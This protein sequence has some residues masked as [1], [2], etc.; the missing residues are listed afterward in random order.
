MHP[1]CCALAI[2]VV[3]AAAMAGCNW[4]GRESASAGAGATKPQHRRSWSDDDVEKP[5]WIKDPT[6]GGKFIAAWGSAAHDPYVDTAEIRDRAVNSARKE[7]ARMVAVKVQ[8]VM[9]DYVGASQSDTVSFSQNIARAIAVQSVKGSYQRDEWVH[10]KTREMFVWV[11][12]DPHFKEKLA[13]TIGNA[14]QEAASK[15]PALAAHL[16]AK[17]ESDKGFAELDRLLDRSFA[18]GGAA[19]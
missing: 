13:Q 10:P 6:Q 1:R 16:R 19:K 4:A 18:E 2:A 17:A 12:V 9:Q 3:C 14:A 8:A 15:D 7:L 11:V 5:G